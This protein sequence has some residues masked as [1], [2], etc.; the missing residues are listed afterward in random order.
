M[1]PFSSD[2][3][4]NKGVF[5]L[6]VSDLAGVC[7]RGHL[8]ATAH[9]SYEGFCVGDIFSLFVLL[10][11]FSFNPLGTDFAYLLLNYFPRQIFH[12]TLM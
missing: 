4:H 9:K 11:I 8:F 12:M 6:A 5:S 10:E 7:H 2:L 1:T 3:K